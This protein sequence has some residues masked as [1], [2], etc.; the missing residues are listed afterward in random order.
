[1]FLESVFLERDDGDGLVAKSCTTIQS[2][3]P[4]GLKSTRLLRPWD[5][6]GK[7]MEWVA[8]LSPGDLADPEIKPGSP[9]LQVDSLPAEPQRKPII[10]IREAHYLYSQLLNI[11]LIY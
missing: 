4:C 8:F 1:M 5:F 9:T 3:R 6:P 11:N 2:M 10:Y 7:A